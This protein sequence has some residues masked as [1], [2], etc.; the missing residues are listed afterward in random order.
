MDELNGNGRVFV[1][2][3]VDYRRL[4]NFGQI[5]PHLQLINSLPP[6]KALRAGVKQGGATNMLLSG[7]QTG[8]LWD[9][10]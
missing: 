4:I 6:C 3:V 2:G 7:P 1:S 8:V 5:N 9:E 10:L